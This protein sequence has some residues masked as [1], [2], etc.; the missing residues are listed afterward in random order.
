MRTTSSPALTDA[1]SVRGI[2]SP[3][4][5]RKTG[6]SIVDWAEA[7]GFNTNLVYAVIRGER[8]CLRGESFRIAKELGMK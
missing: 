1:K 5:F 6:V 8:K 4:D 2:R 3:S 7:Y